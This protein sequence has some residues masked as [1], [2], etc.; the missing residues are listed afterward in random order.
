MGRGFEHGKAW[1]DL[2]IR[3][4]TLMEGGSWIE[5]TGMEMGMGWVCRNPNE[6]G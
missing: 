4:A 6:Q 2:H 3:D 5:G 1:L